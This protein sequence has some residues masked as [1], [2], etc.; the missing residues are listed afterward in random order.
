MRLWYQD[1]EIIILHDACKGEDIIKECVEHER[2]K[3][4]PLGKVTK[5]T[6][7]VDDEGYLTSSAEFTKIP[8]DRIRRITGY[9]AYDN[10]INSA[11]TE[12]I[13]DRISHQL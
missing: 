5:V 12:E 13:K 6:I 8:F 3:Y 7:G 2:K 10:K 11:K 9:L 1:V 4:E